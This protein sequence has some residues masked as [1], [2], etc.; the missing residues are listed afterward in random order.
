MSLV[1][2]TVQTLRVAREVPPYGYF[3]TDG[4]TDVLMHYNEIIGS[5]PQ[6]GDE[7]EV[8][9]FHDTEDRLA[10]TMKRPL[11]QL[12]ELGRLRVADVNPRLGCF[13]EMG[14]GRQ[15]LLPISELPERIEYRPLPGDEVYVRMDHDKAG[16]LLARTAR[17]EELAKLVFTAP[18]AWRNEWVEGWVTKTLQMGSFVLIDGGVVGFGAY[19]LIPDSE[20]PHPLRLG[21]RVRA[22]VTY[23]REDGRVNLSMAERKEIGRVEDADRILSFLQE[24]PNGSMPYSDETPA[25]IVKQKFGISKSAFK[26]ALGKLMREGRIRQ[27][28]SWTHL[29]PS[30][31]AEEERKE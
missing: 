12:G 15:L 24:R 23:V 30:G 10:S 27:E 20:R 21:Q 5:R 11:L 7:L 26:R 16:R 8:F 1:A 14:L 2:G 22:R 4:S 3:L 19:G 31:S 17:E 6:P 28:G 25:D 13:L 9:I 18:S 29:I